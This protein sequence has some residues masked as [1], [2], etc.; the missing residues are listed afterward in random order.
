MGNQPDYSLEVAHEIDEEVRKLIEAAHTEAWEILNTYRDVL[1]DLVYELLQKETLTRVDLERIFGHGREAAA[2]HRVQR[3]RSA[4][5]VGQAADQD[6]RR[7]RHERGEPWP[8]TPSR[9]ASPARRLV[10]GLATA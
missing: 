9:P 1:D 10:P 5:A 3:L 7:A 6:A 2:D 4:H 8:P